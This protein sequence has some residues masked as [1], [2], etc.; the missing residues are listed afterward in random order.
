MTGERRDG[1]G[2]LIDPETLAAFIDGQLPEDER[3]RVLAVLA[4]SDADLE[5]LADAAAVVAELEGQAPLADEPAPADPGEHRTPHAAPPASRPGAEAERSAF[6]L[7]WR[8]GL[9]LAA[10]LAAL[11]LW[12]ALRPGVPAPTTLDWLGTELALLSD[13]P[14]PGGMPELAWAEPTRSG[15]AADLEVLDALTGVARA[16]REGVLMARLGALPTAERRLAPEYRALLTLLSRSTAGTAASGT[17]EAWV[18]GDGAAAAES[19]AGTADAL[20]TL[21]GHPDAFRLGALTARTT[22]V[23]APDGR[24]P[25]G[26]DGVVA[27]LQSLVEKLPAEARVELERPFSAVVAALESPSATDADRM[28]ALDALT[29]AAASLGLPSSDP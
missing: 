8:I 28:E 11:A 24:L 5:V 1:P 10:V 29:R 23:L 22:L 6:P 12:P 20:A 9:P 4:E 17:V 21:E 15:E 18:E 25:T 7:S 16:F 26:E 14:P 2:P 19:W 13:A 27:A 3:A